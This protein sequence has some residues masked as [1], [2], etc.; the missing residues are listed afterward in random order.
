MREL[1]DKYQKYL[2]AFANTDFGRD[3]LSQVF[4]IK[5][6]PIFKVTPDSVHY[7]TGEGAI[8]T[9]VSHSKCLGLFAS[10]LTAIDVATGNGAR[11]VDGIERVVPHYQ[12]LIRPV[13][14]FPGVYLNQST[15]NP[16]ADPESTTVDG[17]LQ[18]SNQASWATAH[19]LTTASGAFP[20]DANLQALVNTNYRVYR[21]IMLFDTSSLTADAT[22]DTVTLPKVSLYVSSVTG[23]SGSYGIC[24]SSPASNT[25]LVVG[26]LDGFTVHSDTVAAAAAASS[27]STTAYNDFTWSSST[28]NSWISL[29]SVTKLGYRHSIDYNETTGHSSPPTDTQAMTSNSADGANPPQLVISYT[30]PTMGATIY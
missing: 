3:Y 2:V 9:F 8:A 29:T 25:N 23:T 13:S 17:Q 10:S 16:D 12:Q 27:L 21:T 28:Y 24:Q 4:C 14:E 22:L 5:D 30:L 1:F 6:H 7:W 19:D 18:E 15:F 20:S 26:D 11:F